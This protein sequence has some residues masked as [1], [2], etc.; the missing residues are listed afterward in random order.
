MGEGESVGVVG[1]VVEGLAGSRLGV[2]SGPALHH[3]C[4]AQLGVAGRWLASVRETLG[5]GS[6]SGAG[7]AWGVVIK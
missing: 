5:A 2:G 3:E 7:H 6:E 4:Q 1:W